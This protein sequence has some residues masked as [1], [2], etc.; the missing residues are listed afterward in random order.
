MGCCNWFVAEVSKNGS[1]SN[2][3]GPF[4]TID[5]ARTYLKNSFSISSSQHGLIKIGPGIFSA[6]GDTI[7]ATSAGEDDYIDYEGSG[8]DITVIKRTASAFVSLTTASC[9]NKISNMTLEYNGSTTGEYVMTVSNCTSVVLNNCKI[10]SSHRC[11]DYL[12]TNAKMF[13]CAVES[14]STVAETVVHTV[15]GSMSNCTV[16]ANSLASPGYLFSIVA[17][18]SV[19]EYCRFTASNTGSDIRGCGNFQGRLSHSYLETGG[20]TIDD[21]N[22]NARLEYSRIVSSGASGGVVINL[23]RDTVVDHC[24][25]HQKGNV[26]VINGVRANASIITDTVLYGPAC[27]GNLVNSVEVDGTIWL[28]CA[29]YS[30]TSSTGWSLN[31]S[32]AG[33]TITI[34][35]ITANRPL[36]SDFA[37]T[38]VFER[39]KHNVT[40]VKTAAYT[41]LINDTVRCNPTGGAFTVTLPAVTAG[42]GGMQI[43]VKN[44]SSSANTITIARAGAD[45]IDGATTAT[46]SAAY[47]KLTLESDGTSEWMIVG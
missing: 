1:D 37:A 27:T 38:Y 26:P 13:H 20:Y 44:T 25:L 34:G 7:V 16:V 40:A 46:I 6:S 35:D 11:I 9:E 22:N 36:D 28:G 14:T 24:F 29:F 3:C 4:A 41:A 43:T 31:A 12:H 30:S 33:R 2:P 39:G 47:G 19:L 32:A 15:Y 42:N 17:D 23:I 8:V 18:T 10:K 5:A 45:T 21:L